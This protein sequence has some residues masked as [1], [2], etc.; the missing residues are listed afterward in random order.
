LQ[1]QL[2]EPPQTPGKD[3]ASYLAWVPYLLCRYG[4]WTA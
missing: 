3:C 2:I 1:S 4:D